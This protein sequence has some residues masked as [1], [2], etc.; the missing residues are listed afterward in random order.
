[1]SNAQFQ[2]ELKQAEKD[3]KKDAY[4]AVQHGS[5]TVAD[6]YF[7]QGNKMVHQGRAFAKKFGLNNSKSMFQREY[8]TP[9][10][11]LKR[12][13]DRYTIGS[14]VS[15]GWT[16]FMNQPTYRTRTNKTGVLEGTIKKGK[17][18]SFQHMD[19]KNEA[20]VMK[21]INSLNSKTYK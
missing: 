19:S 18:L 15:A 9:K 2:A 1:M 7:S 3:M 6:I 8:S 4:D 17:Q 21:E 12:G 14:S 20:S 10:M 13:K 11:T 16:K 5:K